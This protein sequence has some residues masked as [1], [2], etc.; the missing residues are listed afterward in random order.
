MQYL[1][2]PVL[3]PVM[4]AYGFNGIWF[5][6]V[7]VILMELGMLTPPMGINLFIVK[8]IAK[9]SKMSDIVKGSFPY[10]LLMLLMIMILTF[11]PSIVTF[12]VV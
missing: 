11:F 8:G 4:I 5:G 2:L 12:L 10:I 1:T 7:L 9:N 3:Y 6:V